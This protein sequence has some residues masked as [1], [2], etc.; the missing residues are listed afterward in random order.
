M[1]W[2]AAGLVAACGGET[3]TGTGTGAGT[4]TG[5]GAGAPAA[6]SDGT[7]KVTLAGSVNGQS[8]NVVDAA[9]VT[10]GSDRGVLF[11]NRPGACTRLASKVPPKSARRLGVIFRNA[12]EGIKVGTYPLDAKVI[13]S[14]AS[15]D[16]ACAPSFG[17]MA[18]SGSVVIEAVDATGVKGSLTA[19]FGD[20]E[21]VTASFVVP[22]CGSAPESVDGVCE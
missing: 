12:A 9:F 10:D 13:V 20:T 14:F 2:V 19:K 8:V 6:V 17:T 1:A 22:T 7:A 16:E 21:E 18:S 5:T 3:S 4:G 11:L 15:F